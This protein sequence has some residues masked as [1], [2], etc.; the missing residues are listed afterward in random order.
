M[1]YCLHKFRRRGFAKALVPQ[2]VK[3]NFTN[4]Q[5]QSFVYIV[6]SNEASRNLFLDLGWRRESDADWFG[7][8]W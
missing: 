5:R 1:L 8:S 4:G 3:E 2:A 7:L 6:D